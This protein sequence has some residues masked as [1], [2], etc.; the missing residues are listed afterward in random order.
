MKAKDTPERF[1]RRKSSPNRLNEISFNA[2]LLKEL[3]MIAML[4]QVAMPA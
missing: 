1:A 3:P 2:T 4:R